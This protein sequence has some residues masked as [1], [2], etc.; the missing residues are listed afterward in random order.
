MY[1]HI[2]SRLEQY[3]NNIRT[4]FNV[5]YKNTAMKMPKRG[6]EKGSIYLSFGIIALSCIMIPCCLIVGYVSQVMTQALAMV[7]APTAGLLAELHIMSAFSMVFGILVIFSVLFF[8]SDREHLIPLPFKPYEILTAKFFYSYLAESV[9]EFLVIISIFVGFFIAFPGNPVSYI[10]AIIGVIFVPLLPLVY[11][12][13][14]CMIIMLLLR[15][16]KNSAIFDHISTIFMWIFIGLFLLSF[17]DMGSINMANYVDSLA[18][19][20]NTFFSLLN[21]IF[22]T[23]PILLKAI[24]KGSL[25][26]LAAYIGCNI[27]MLLIMIGIGSIAYLPGLQ[28]VARLGGKKKHFISSNQLKH[29]SAFSSYFLKDL[30]VLLRAKAYRANCVLINLIWPAGMLLIIALNKDKAGF[31]QVVNMYQQGYN[32]ALILALGC[33]VI[34]SFIATAMNSL[35]STAFSREGAHL[36]LIKYIPVSYK[37]QMYA[38]GLISIVLT[39]PALLLTIIIWGIA[40][41]MSLLLYPLYAMIALGCIL[42]TT[43]LGLYLDSLHPHS[44]WEDEY[45]ALRGNL[46]SFFDMALVMVI[47]ILIAGIPFALFG[48]GFI[49][50]N[51]YY[52]FISFMLIVGVIIALTKGIDGIL[53]N[54]DEL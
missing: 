16:V 39:Y 48:L 51:G 33:I 15:N 42:I 46:N 7:D 2:L 25:L 50:V 22:F 9:M 37:K 30:K 49:Q 44:E 53:K 47:S 4:L 26:W 13:I 24:E 35:A 34:I 41:K 11:C 38:K 45:S 54:M 10:A 12:A 19:N 1:T 5:L 17:K 52:A 40:S 3:M 27:I 20:N 43:V 14:I 18:N 8:S 32:R 21:K 31:K 28:T 36:S 23:I 29:R 6:T